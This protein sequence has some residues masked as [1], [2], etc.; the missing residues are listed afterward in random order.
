MAPVVDDCVAAGYKTVSVIARFLT[1]TYYTQPDPARNGQPKLRGPD[2]VPNGETK[3][4]QPNS[5]PNGQP[6]QSLSSM[7]TKI[8]QHIRDLLP[9]SS[10]ACFVL[11]NRQ[12][13]TALGDQPLASL[14]TKNQITERRR[15]LLTMQKD[16]PGWLLCY[17]CSLFHPVKADDLVTRRVWHFSEEPPCVYEAGAVDLPYAYLLRYQLAQL[18][19]NQYRFQRSYTTTLEAL[20]FSS[21]TPIDFCLPRGTALRDH[22]WEVTIWCEIAAGQL[23]LRF[24]Q[25]LRL[26]A[27]SNTELMDITGKLLRPVCHHTG[28]HFIKPDE[29]HLW[30]TVE[31]ALS[32]GHNP[33][34]ADCSMRKRCRECSTWFQVGV[35]E[36]KG[37]GTE[38]W[39]QAWKYLGTCEIPY[40][41][42]WRKQAKRWFEDDK[43]KLITAAQWPSEG[44]IA[45][46][47]KKLYCECVS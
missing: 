33:P 25:K 42:K 6:K 11:C 10:A 32:H 19:M 5:I 45:A 24:D 26:P 39:I 36:L 12:M 22:V 15:F 43:I 1:G 28:Y 31:C 30:E 35:Q 17:H 37:S 44:Y 21:S 13:L 3:L 47:E 8:L 41:P 18:L 20:S 14:R 40:D 34:C 27:L 29:Q 46:V 23:I 7:P 2:P 38:V 16:L 9:L 4:C